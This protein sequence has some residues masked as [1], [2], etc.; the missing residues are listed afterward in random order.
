MVAPSHVAGLE[1]GL[2]EA[3]AAARLQAEGPNELPTAKPRGVFATAWD[4]VREPMILLLVGAGAIYLFLGELRDSAVLLVSIFV[5]IG[6]SLYQER[7]TEHALEALRDLSSPR[8]LVIRDGQQRRVAGRE[9][10]RGDLVVLSEGDR[11]PA[12]GVVLSA[13]NLSIDESLLTGES[14]PVRKAA[15]DGHAEMGRP[16]GDDLPFV[17]SGTLVVQGQGFAEIKATGARTELGRIGKALQRV[18]TEQTRLQEEVGRLA[19]ILATLGLSLCFLIV[20]AYGLTRGRWIDGFLVG[21]TTAMSL[22]PEE[23]PVVLTIFLALGAWRISQKRVLTRRN[24]AIEALGSA[25][26]LCVDK[27]GT[28]TQNRMAVQELFAAGQYLELSTSPSRSLPEQFHEV[29]EY[30]ILSSKRNPFDPMEIAFQQFG[31][32]FLRDTE[33][34]HPGWNLV[35]EYPLTPKLLA[36]SRVWESFQTGSYVL[37]A[38]GAPE[39]I[40]ELCR[41]PKS[42][43]ENITWAASQMAGRGF[44]VLGV[45]KGDVRDS[46][47]PDDPHALLWTFV[48]LVGLADPIRPEVPAAVRECYGAGIRVVMITGDYPATAQNIAVQIGMKAPEHVLTGKEIEA[49]D[50]QQLRERVQATDIFAR[51][52]PEQKL[53]L[54]NAL[55]ANG[56]VV[57]MTGDGVNDAPALKAAQIGI[58]MGGRGTDVAREA[59]DLVL[60]DDSFTS[61]VDAIRLGRRIFDNLRKAMSFVFAVHVPIA[62]LALIP[63]LLKWPLVLMPVHVVFLELI[64]DPACSVAFEAEPGEPGLMQRHPRRAGEPL[65]PRRHLTFSFFQGLSVLAAVIA[66]FAV[67]LYRGEPATNARALTFST[68]VIAN[69]M[70]ILANRSW[71]RVIISTLRAP[72]PA[73]WWVVGGAVL[74][75]ALS[76]YVPFLRSLFRFSVLHLTDIGICLAAGGASLL[77]FEAW[78]VA[79]NWATATRSA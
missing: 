37:A 42:E 57:A 14:V 20:V 28:L 64:I 23:F 11:V 40:A 63:V 16:G 53:Q 75:L 8:A 34:L 54:V 77:W 62:G 10:V 60:L 69:L 45:A 32:R 58:A 65:L 21:I 15:W 27:T 51:V 73:L 56:E 18:S 30:S 38:K 33:H 6:I 24:N 25:T 9:V 74:V 78:K 13:G 70:L 5:V 44:R 3:E 47:L 68:L 49:L 2:S 59:A 4:I 52:V 50:D 22:L 48:G 31:A 1:S 43:M 7:K 46:N 76:I 61:I 79:R 26:V 67:A 55:K 12:D 35:R 71:T 39:A 72:N 66:V 19:R 29:V 17:F 36:V 41:T